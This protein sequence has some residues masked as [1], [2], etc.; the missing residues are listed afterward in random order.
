M[1]LQT[2]K[3]L[4]FELRTAME[5]GTVQDTIFTWTDYYKYFLTECEKNHRVNKRLC[6]ENKRL[7]NSWKKTHAFIINV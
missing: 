3:L 6:A 7:Y 4:S 5:D 2:E 1:C